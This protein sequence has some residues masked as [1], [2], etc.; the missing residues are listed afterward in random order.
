MNI[1]SEGEFHTPSFGKVCVCVP[2]YSEVCVCVCVC[3]QYVKISPARSLTF[4][5]YDPS[6]VLVRLCLL[7]E[8]FVFCSPWLKNELTL[9]YKLQ[10]LLFLLTLVDVNWCCV[11]LNRWGLTIAELWS[12]HLS[13]ARECL[14]C[15]ND[16]HTSLPLVWRRIRHRERRSRPI[17]QNQNTDLSC[18]SVMHVCR[19]VCNLHWNGPSR[20][21]SLGV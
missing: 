3:A 20:N 15:H 18:F 11:L 10:F 14:L 6:A 9:S 12:S 1:R 8:L 21:S 2:S 7:L 4:I 13:H 16:P 5:L 17:H 19:L